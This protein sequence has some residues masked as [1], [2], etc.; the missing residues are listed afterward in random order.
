MKSLPARTY[1]TQFPLAG[2]K[3]SQIRDMFKVRRQ[4]KRQAAALPCLR[5]EAS[6]QIQSECKASSVRKTQAID[7]CCKREGIVTSDCRRESIKQ[8]FHT[9]MTGSHRGLSV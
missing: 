8:L 3:E 9:A 5:W 7:T 6:L 1:N 2:L 4:H